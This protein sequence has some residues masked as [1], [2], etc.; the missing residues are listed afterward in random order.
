LAALPCFEGSDPD[1]FDSAGYRPAARKCI[2]EASVRPLTA[3]ISPS[4]CS[5]WLSASFD[6]RCSI[7]G[8]LWSG[9]WT[10]AIYRCRALALLPCVSWRPDPDRFSLGRRSSRDALA[11]TSLSRQRCTTGWHRHPG[12]GSGADL[13]WVAEKGSWLKVASSGLSYLHWIDLMVVVNR[14]TALWVGFALDCRSAALAALLP[15]RNRRPSASGRFLAVLLAERLC[16]G[17]CRRT[18]GEVRGS[19]WVRKKTSSRSHLRDRSR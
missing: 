8:A 11:L 18:L 17:G 9:R 16:P 7:V 13:T 1:T 5:W 3:L 6:D 12:P 19:I 2:V 14:R 10:V 4:L 15:T